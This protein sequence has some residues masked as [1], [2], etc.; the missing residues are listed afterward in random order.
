MST[1]R[2]ELFALASSGTVSDSTVTSEPQVNN[3]HKGLHL[4]VRRTAETGTCTL[5]VKVQ[6]FAG[7]DMA[8]VAAVEGGS[9]TA[10]AWYDVANSDLVTFADGAT[11]VKYVTLYPGMTGS[12]ADGVV[13]QD[14]DF[15]LANGVLPHIWRVSVTHGGTSVS[16][17]F[18]IYC[19]LIP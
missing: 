4:I 6:G 9:T 13:L 16:N 11:G 18:A 2:R 17:T 5:A 12:D 15:T 19:D 8:A 7:K 14:T 3:W 1:I 10:G